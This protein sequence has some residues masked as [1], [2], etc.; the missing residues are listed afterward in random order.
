MRKPTS[1]CSNGAKKVI[2]TAPAKEE[3]LTIVMG[4]NHNDYDPAKHH[5]VS[6]ASCTTNCLAPVAL[7]VERRFGIVSGAMTTVHADTND[8]RIRD[9]PHKDLRRAR[10]AACNI[11]P[12]STGAAQA[13]AKVIPSLK[14]KFT[15]WSLRVPTPTV[16]VVDFTAILN[17]DTDTDTMRAALKEAAE[18][19][20]KGILAYS[21]AQL[22]SMVMNAVRCTLRAV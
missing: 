20:L 2:I 8:Q 16:S 17:K 10:A 18:G 9:L 4:V 15:G 14:G 1:I 22:V 11:I 5:V 19:E 13:V 3:D 6:N 12:T 7:V 21:D